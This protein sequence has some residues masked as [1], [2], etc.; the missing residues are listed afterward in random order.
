MD[1]PISMRIEETRSSI[2]DIINESKLHPSIIELMLKGIYLE[3]V[4]LSNE[5]LNKEKNQF[6]DGQLAKETNINLQ[7]STSQG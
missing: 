2:V 4:M 3:A 6:I 5:I 1:K 7:E